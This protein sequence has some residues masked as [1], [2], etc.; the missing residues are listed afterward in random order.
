M[1]KHYYLISNAV[2]EVGELKSQLVDVGTVKKR[3]AIVRKLNAELELIA[4]GRLLSQLD[5]DRFWQALGCMAYSAKGLLS[6]SNN[7][8]KPSVPSSM[9][10]G[11][12][13][14]IASE[15]YGLAQDLV[16]LSSVEQVNPEYDD[17]FYQ[18][19]LLHVLLANPVIDENA[20]EI[21]N[22]YCSSMEAYLEETPPIVEF[23]RALVDAK[24]EDITA[25]FTAWC[26]QVF[27][28]MQTK[29]ERGNSLLAPLKQHVW[30]EGLAY[31]RLLNRMGIDMP[32]TLSGVPDLIRKPVKHKFVEAYDL[33]SPQSVSAEVL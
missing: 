22:D 15:Q 9:N 11:L 5:L 29:T 28:Q 8:A 16:K 12:I 6:V 25:S 32:I 24:V 26:E 3:I 1:S 13:A 20:A 31:I 17:E 14:A 23:Y 4:Y 21:I 18:A 30:L 2:A 7:T 27:N 33:F 19:Q 10:F